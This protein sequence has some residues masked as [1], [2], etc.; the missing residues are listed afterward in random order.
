MTNIEGGIL[1]MLFAA[2]LG[3]AA[4][5]MTMIIEVCDKGEKR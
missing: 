1:G 2:V 5:L 3:V 4:V